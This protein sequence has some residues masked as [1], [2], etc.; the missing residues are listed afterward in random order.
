MTT[1]VLCGNATR[2]LLTLGALQY[3][4][5]QNGNLFP[6]ENFVATSSGG[7]LSLLIVLGYTPIEMLAKFCTESTSSILTFNLSNV[8]SGNIASFTPVRH[9][10][11]QMIIDK[12]GYIPTFSELK[13]RCGKNLTITAYNLT[14]RCGEYLNATSCPELSILDGIQAS[15]N[16]PFVF[17]HF[18]INDCF[19]LDGAMFDNFPVDYATRHYG[20]DIIGIV[21]YIQITEFD[22]NIFKYIMNLFNIFITNYQHKNIENNCKIIKLYTTEY[23]FINFSKHGYLLFDEGYWYCKNIYLRDDKI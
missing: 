3:I 15:C 2:A 16:F 17:E 18:Q 8:L 9:I 23:N 12:V 19:Y 7:I 14:K 5:E 21:T 20:S 11:Q 4:Y 10:L 6:F 1:L 22:G 13:T